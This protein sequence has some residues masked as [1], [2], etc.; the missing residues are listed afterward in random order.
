MHL[1][2]EKVV[3]FIDQLRLKKQF[4][5]ATEKMLEQ[6]NNDFND[7]MEF[8]NEGVFSVVLDS[9]Q[10]KI[11]FVI[12]IKNKKYVLY[13]HPNFDIYWDEA[14]WTIARREIKD[15]FFDIRKSVKEKLEKNPT[16]WMRIKKWVGI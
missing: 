12:V 13:E 3:A 11:C 7:V 9:V 2:K 16:I 4:D 15:S 1:E 5:D 6:V 8:V 14:S 10:N